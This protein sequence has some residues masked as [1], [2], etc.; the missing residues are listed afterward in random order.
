MIEAL[1]KKLCDHGSLRLNCPIW[2]MI[3]VW[4]GGVIALKTQTGNAHFQIYNSILWKILH[5]S[6]SANG[7]I[8]H[9][10]IP[11]LWC[12]F[13][14]H[15]CDPH[16]LSTR[17]T[18]PIPFVSVF[19][20]EAFTNQIISFVIRNNISEKSRQ[21]NFKEDVYCTICLYGAIIIVVVAAAFAAVNETSEKIDSIKLSV[22]K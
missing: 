3:L 4:D 7:F 1:H 14:P 12:S 5:F 8:S 18:T 11:N 6:F 2:F 20:F 22:V 19:L 16:F 10:L 17:S 15:I 21:Y 9:V 13:F